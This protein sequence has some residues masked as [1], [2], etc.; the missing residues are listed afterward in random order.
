MKKCFLVIALNHW[1]LF[2]ILV[3]EKS[4]AEPHVNG[5]ITNVL[6]KSELSRTDKVKDIGN[7]TYNQVW[8]KPTTIS[9]SKTRISF[10]YCN[11]KPRFILRGDVL[12]TYLLR[13][14]LCQIVSNQPWFEEDCERQLYAFTSYHKKAYAKFCNPSEYAMTCQ[15]IQIKPERLPVS[16]IRSW[17]SLNN[18][19]TSP[20]YVET[21]N[22]SF[23]V[24]NTN[25]HLSPFDSM[26]CSS[27]ESYFDVVFE[28]I[29]SDEKFNLSQNGL[30]P[31]RNVQY[32]EWFLR[33]REFCYAT[34]CGVTM[35]N[36]TTSP[37]TAYDCFPPS[38]RP[39][40]VLDMVIDG[41]ICVLIVVANSLVI[42]VFIRSPA[43]KNIPGY[44]KMSL[45][46]A[47]LLVGVI[48]MPAILYNHY[49]VSFL[50]L[51]FREEGSLPEHTDYF[52]QAYLNA[53]GFF[54]NLGEIASVYT[55]C[56]ASVDR[57]FAIAQPFK[58]DE[59]KY[60]TKKNSICV[61]LGIW[62]FGIL[63]SI[64][65]I[66]SK[67]GYGISGVDLVLAIGNLPIIVYSI[68]LG[69]PLVA[70]WVFNIA[71]FASVRKQNRKR[72]SFRKAS[73]FANTHSTRTN[74]RDLCL[75]TATNGRRKTQNEENE[76]D[77]TAY[78]SKTI[79]A[80]SE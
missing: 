16:I 33:F 22:Y 79:G 13:L 61:I 4:C 65:P 62:L 3:F 55:L 43:I 14:K 42:I 76:I 50:P 29:Q 70:V 77:L 37:V 63:C 31:F 12:L 80:A 7:F 5:K 75:A 28:Q 38:C 47:D 36:Y 6:N 73:N 1:C 49:V 41:I 58:Y 72:S 35:E 57:Y 15:M 51:P 9:D 30:L 24:G 40:F 74:S 8:S 69:L 44:F 21:R 64:V 20:E 71:V 48:V 66:F 67:Y 60:F 10:S 45:A 32:T 19:S 78:N 34:A 17:V 11:G 2:V 46:F 53:I 68:A 52:S 39:S 26:I 27:I 23:I 54:T 56:A 18:I 25:S 59:G